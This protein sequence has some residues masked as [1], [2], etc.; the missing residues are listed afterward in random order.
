L[1]NL[2]KN[3]NGGIMIVKTLLFLLGLTISSYSIAENKPS[4]NATKSQPTTTSTNN[5]TNTPS[6]SAQKKREEKPTL[7]E[8]CKEHT[9]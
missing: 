2:L 9:C 3:L 5:S 1:T 8:Y 4:T 6:N 7:A